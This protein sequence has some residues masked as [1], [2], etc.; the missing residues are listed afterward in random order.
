MSVLKKAKMSTTDV[1]LSQ[2]CESGYIA[3]VP[4]HPVATH[5]PIHLAA[6]PPVHV[7]ARN[8]RPLSK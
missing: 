8:V 7:V 5:Q 4:L 1:A 6:M 3:R 2:K